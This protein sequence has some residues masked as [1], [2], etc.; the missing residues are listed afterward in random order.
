MV[1]ARPVIMSGKHVVR[2]PR[3]GPWDA[4]DR[5]QP[6]RVTCPNACRTAKKA[7]PSYSRSGRL[8]I[9]PPDLHALLIES[10][11][12][13]A[14]F[15]L[16]REGHVVSWNPGAERIK[17]YTASEIIGQH[18][19]RFYTEEDLLA[20]I[21]AAA[22]RLADT[23]GRF[24]AEGWRLRKDGT[25]FW[26]SVVID[27]IRG[28]G[29]LIGFAKVTRDMTEQREAHLA[30]LDSERRFRLLVQGVSDYA[31]F[32]LDLGGHVTNWNAGEPNNFRYENGEEEHCLELWNRDGKGLKWNDTPCSFETYFICEV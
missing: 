2:E 14:I 11:L 20:G 10:V 22:L 13:Y 12:D 32:M 9:S 25:R 6:N 4:A 26:A 16:D 23:E 8:D 19:S 5:K 21:P 28:G 27:P 1:C 17:G 15:M 7:D 30:A 3:H 24:A 18:F 31:I 29:K